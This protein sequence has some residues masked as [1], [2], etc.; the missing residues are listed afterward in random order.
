MRPNVLLIVL[1]AARADHFEPYGAPAG[2]TPVIADLARRGRHVPLAYAAGSWTVPSHAALFSGLLPRAAGLSRAPGGTP[3]GCRPRLE[4]LR[5]RLLAE[6]LRRNGYETRGLSTNAWLLPGGGFDIGFEHFELVDPS[7]DLE[8]GAKGRRSA[9]RAALEAL[10]A[11]VDD[12]ARAASDIIRRWVGEPRDRPFFWFVNLVEAHS[13]YLPPKPFNDLRPLERMRAAIEA[14]RYLSLGSVW[15]ASVGE[16]E[17]PDDVIGRMR[18]LYAASIRALDAWVG[19]TL[20]LLESAGLADD[21]LV[22]VTADHGENLGE[23][24]MLGHSFSL[25]ERLLR[26]PFV[27]AGPV[28]IGDEE[29]LSLAALPNRLGGALE[30]PDHPWEDPLPDGVAI[31]QF[32]PPTRLGDPRNDLLLRLW[33]VGDHDGMLVRRLTT[34][35]SCAT[36]GRSKLLRRGA[37]EEL[38]DLRTDPFERQPR[39]PDGSTR[40]TVKRLR[41]ALDHATEAPPA[42][43][44]AETT[45]DTDEVEALE[46]RMR[47]LGYM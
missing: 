36:D 27:T 14:R 30:L 7:R 25:D 8:V 19:E 35:L 16:L 2:S 28:G 3:Q 24:G 21:T 10:R 45:L 13:P 39:A 18:R 6:V 17:V 42:L 1:D 33:D 43:A 46:K 38:Y 20:E 37:E 47:L 11:D 12:G 9:V 41:G 15:R 31:A 32:D 34:E 4:S 40:E 26:V 22:I 44:Q 5:G 23:N 29:L